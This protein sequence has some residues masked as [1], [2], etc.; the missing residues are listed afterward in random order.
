MQAAVMVFTPVSEAAEPPAAPA[1][2]SVSCCPTCGREPKL[3]EILVAFDPTPVYP[4]QA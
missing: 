1:D 2:E 4:E 3:I